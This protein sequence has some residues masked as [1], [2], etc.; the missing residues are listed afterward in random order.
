MKI[1]VV[2]AS[3]YVGGRLVP[4]LAGQ[5]HE[6]V[7]ASR[8]PRPLQ[9]RYPDASVI[10]ADLLDP[11]S[12]PAAVAG[13]EFAYYLAHSMGTSKSDFAERDVRGAANF[14][15][16]AAAAGVRRII[17][18]GGLGDDEARLSRHLASRHWTG[19]EL[20]GHGVPVT[21]F[22]AA[23][24]IGSGSA[25]FEILRHLTERLPVMITPRWVATRCQPI[26]IRDVLAYLVAAIDHPEVTGIVEIGGPD[27][28]SY[29]EMMMAYARQRGLRRLMIPVPVLTPRLSSYWVSLVSPVPSAVAR[30]LIDGLRNEVVVRD[31]EPARAFDVTPMRYE[32]ALARAIRRTE[33]SDVES[34]WFDAYRA[35]DRSTLGSRNEEG[36]LV[37]RRVIN[38]AA[39]PE[40]VFAEVQR[41][42]GATGWPYGNV[43]WRIRGFADRAVG[44]V[45]LRLGRRD[46]NRVRVGDAIDFWR[47]EEV[48]PPELLRLRDAMKLPGRA[49]LQ[50]EI[51]SIGDGR[52]SQLVQT[53]FFEPHGLPGLVYWYGLMPVHP[54]MFKGMITELA[55][56]AVARAGAAG[57]E[58]A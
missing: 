2:G 15:R 56:R 12:L 17:Y 43:L 27:V 25:S 55:A 47:V 38:V 42:G 32:E 29:G 6:L 37:D 45:G 41:V 53:A 40:A 22:R 9:A 52:S 24:I 35:R 13:V 19:A 48:H 30:P 14:A 10:R 54:T 4:L 21:E 20:A 31:P 5:G 8:N 36:M 57:P 46:P 51:L 50:Y 34:T 58:A 33:G 3:G 49:W 23:V 26:A 39:P 7:L 18:L 1:L 16:A 11:A 44:G 28:L